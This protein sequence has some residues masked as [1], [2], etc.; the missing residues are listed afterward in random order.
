[1]AVEVIEDYGVIHSRSFAVGG[2]QHAS[3][4]HFMIL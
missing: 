2:I 3:R 1:M 4:S